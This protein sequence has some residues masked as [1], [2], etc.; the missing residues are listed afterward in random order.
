M[1]NIINK[2]HKGSIKLATLYLA[3]IFA[4]S[5][6]FS[7]TIYQLSVQ[8]LDRGLRGPR[9]GIERSLGMGFT[10]DIRDN[11]IAE[12]DQAYRLAKERV[13]NRLIITNIIILIGGGFLSYYLALR[14][15]KPIE[16]AQE[17]QNRFTADASHELRTPITAMMTE[18]EVS[19]MNPNLTLK[20]AKIQLAS[21]IEELQKLTNLSD[22]LMRLAGLE[23]SK[24]RKDKVN[25]KSLIEAAVDR[26]AS[27]A[28]AKNIEI[29]IAN[30]IDNTY[31][32]GD[33]QSLQEAL[34][35]LLDNAIKYSPKDTTINISLTKQS[36]SLLI[37]VKDEGIG[38]KAS[39]IPHLFDR[40]Y[41]ADTSRTKQSVQGYGLGLAIAK[42]I[43]TKHSGKIEVISKPNK[44]SAFTISLPA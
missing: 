23:S 43:I 17:S 20:E 33:D 44:G 14:T 18:N 2:F 25:S 7:I 31:I 10:Q 22:G 38:I 3:I 6:F 36:N 40:F 4:I 35:I 29:K 37:C 26:T 16:E 13:L 41:R 27:S 32:L 28:K 19:L 12:R 30:T 15:L 24:M 9:G 21:N 5:M 42:E 11:L 8:E 1:N 39:D 34:V